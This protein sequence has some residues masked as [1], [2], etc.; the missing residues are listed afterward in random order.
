MANTL[1][2][3]VEQSRAEAQVQGAPISDA[4]LLIFFR[5]NLG[6]DR[7]NKFGVARL[8]AASSGVWVRRQVGGLVSIDVT[9]E[10]G[11]R[12]ASFDLKPEQALHIASLLV[13]AAREA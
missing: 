7:A 10:G 13:S 8:E 11:R 9:Q 12:S 2:S 6:K 3:D 1:H 4:D 5:N